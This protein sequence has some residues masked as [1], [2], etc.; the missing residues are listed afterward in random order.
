[1]NIRERIGDV[2]VRQLESIDKDIRETYDPDFGE[3]SVGV[4]D[5]KIISTVFQAVLDEANEEETALHD[6]V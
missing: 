4:S 2:V 5:M 6:T 3:Y 1:M